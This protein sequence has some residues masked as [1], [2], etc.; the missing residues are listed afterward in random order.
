MRTRKRIA[1]VI[2]AAAVFLLGVRH[3]SS[4]CATLPGPDSPLNYPYFAA[5]YLA[6][7]Y[8]LTVYAPLYDLVSVVT[9]LTGAETTFHGAVIRPLG[10]SEPVGVWHKV[11]AYPV[12]VLFAAA[13]IAVWTKV[14]YCS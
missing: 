11:I 9:Y 14:I 6:L 2:V 1:T 8:L 3:A 10:A 5:G 7:F 13:F 12:S 4:T